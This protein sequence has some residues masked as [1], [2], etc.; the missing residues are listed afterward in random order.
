MNKS[1]IWING[2]FID[3]DQAKIHVLSHSLHYGGAVFEGIRCYRTKKGLAVF[4]LNDHLDR[5]FYS[6]K[7]IGLDLVFS[8]VELAEAI[9]KLIKKNNLKECYIRPIVF[10]DYGKMSLN[11]AQGQS[12]FAI[13][14][15][16]WTYL[17]GGGVRAKISKYTKI[18]SGSLPSDAK[19]SGHY[20]SSILATSE[21]VNSGFDEAILLDNKGYVAEG[22]GE[23]IFLIKRGNIYTPERG[24]ILPG[25]TRDSI[26]KIA[27]RRG[28]KIIEKKI[29]PKEL[30]SCD[31]AFFTGTA[32]EVCPILAIDNKKIGRSKPGPITS[33]LKKDYDNTVHGLNSR[34][35]SWLTS[36]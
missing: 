10:L 6:C 26:I 33:L 19:I 32:V 28:I 7:I 23:N 30:I 18:S 9:A 20:A 29:T 24:T 13:A 8:K 27:Q 15:W 4:R 16:A 35:N 14:A 31:E 12:N 11:P 22:P 36:I 3:T 34:Y 5:L 1:K 25:I 2:R 17:S 21:A